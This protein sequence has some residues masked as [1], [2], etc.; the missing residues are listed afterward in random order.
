MNTFSDNFRRAVAISGA[1]S[2]L[3]LPR[4]PRAGADETIESIVDAWRARQARVGAARVEWEETSHEDVSLHSPEPDGPRTAAQGVVEARAL[5]YTLTKRATIAGPRMRYE[6]VGERPHENFPGELVR[7][8]FL[9]AYDGEL[10]TGL[11]PPGRVAAFPSG[12]IYARQACVAAHIVHTQPI[13]WAFTPLE[14]KQHCTR[15]E[16]LRASNRQG[17]ISGRRCLILENSD[18]RVREEMA[19]WVSAEQDYSVLRQAYGTPTTGNT[20]IDITY[21]RDSESDAWVPIRWTIVRLSPDGSP[22][23]TSTS[24][25]T[26]Y[27]INPKLRED[28][29]RIE[30]PIGTVVSDARPQAGGA[31]KPALHYVVRPNGGRRMITNEEMVNATYE[32]WL[33]TETGMA[34]GAGSSLPTARI[35]AYCLLLLVCLGAL[36][37]V[38]GRIVSRGR[39]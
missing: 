9:C 12:Q 3:I 31:K 39:L 32:R 23:S 2:L 7:Q 8:D 19:V 13:R 20:Q 15:L 38:R 11:N 17:E 24:R 26:N 28:E 14:P 4:V 30:F 16:Q 1:L 25:V 36:V 29:F 37:A 35:V 10:S 6:V 22:V 21:D 34:T 18:N 5:D 33:S 27:E